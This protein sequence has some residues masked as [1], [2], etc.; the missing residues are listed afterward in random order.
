[1]DIDVRSQRLLAY[2]GYRI[3][4]AVGDNAA[5]IAAVVGVSEA[6]LYQAAD[7]LFALGYAGCEPMEGSIKRWD[8]TDTGLQYLGR[9]S[10]KPAR[11]ARKDALAWILRRCRAVVMRAYPASL[12]VN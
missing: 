4:A 9:L 7:L 11:P 5:R 6:E 10:E 8:V 1:L 2:L 12:L 3:T